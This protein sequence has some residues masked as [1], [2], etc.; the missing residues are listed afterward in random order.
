MCVYLIIVC[1]TSLL[2][3]VPI[4]VG[5]YMQGCMNACVC[6]YVSMCLCVYICVH[7]CV[8]VGMC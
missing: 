1:A 6:M 3:C 5:R 8:S 7:M 2:V 4:L